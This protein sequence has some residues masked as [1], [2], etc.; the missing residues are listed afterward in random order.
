MELPTWLN[1][2]VPPFNVSN[3]G[4]QFIYYDNERE[5]RII[6]FANR[7]CF[8][9]IVKIGSCTG[10]FL[11]FPHNFFSLIQSMKSITLEMF[12]ERIV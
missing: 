5:D 7:Y 2:A 10:H 8:Y 12:L 9:K 11:Q 4:E 1:N 3:T 6:I